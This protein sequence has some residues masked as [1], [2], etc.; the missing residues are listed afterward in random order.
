M[1]TI[2]EIA[3]RAG[4]SAQAI[5]KKAKKNN[6]LRAVMDEERQQGAGNACFY[7]ER[8]LSTVVRLFSTVD[9]QPPAE[10]KPN[11]EEK[12]AHL[13]A[14]IEHYKAEVERLEKDKEFLQQ[15]LREAGEREKGFIYT[16]NSAHQLLNSNNRKEGFIKRLFGRRSDKE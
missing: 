14:E 13:E 6:E 15:Q 10:Q 2:R 1:F 16:V 8:T 9:N 7:G 11:F 12:I 4:V 5:Y 3:E